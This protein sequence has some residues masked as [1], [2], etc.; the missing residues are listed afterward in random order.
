MEFMKKFARHICIGI[1]GGFTALF[2]LSALAA[3]P[4]H[5]WDT[6]VGFIQTLGNTPAPKGFDDFCDRY[7]ADCLPDVITPDARVELNLERMREL[8]TVNSDVNDSLVFSL[9]WPHDSWDYPD[10]GYGDCEDFAL[11]KR[12]RLIALGWPRD[13]LL[14]TIVRVPHE[15]LPELQVHA[16]LTVRTAQGDYA[17]D[18]DIRSAIPWTRAARVYD[19]VM[20][21]TEGSPRIWARVDSGS[22]L[23]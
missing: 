23:H 20:M 6:P 17:L 13:S 7:P 9:D 18:N 3:Q 22:R 19:Y 5:P 1:I 21:Q 14:L 15:E 2:G 16:L 8:N 4:E 11:E 12:R 10:Q